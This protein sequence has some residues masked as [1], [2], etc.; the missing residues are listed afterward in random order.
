MEEKNLS[1]FDLKEDHKNLLT[2]Y[3]QFIKVKEKKV[4]NEIGFFIQDFFDSK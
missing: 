2:K 4:L 3:I 1:A